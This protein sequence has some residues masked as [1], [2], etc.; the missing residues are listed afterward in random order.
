MVVTSKYLTLG[1][2]EFVNVARCMETGAISGGNAEVQEYEA[3]LSAAFSCAQAIACS[4]GT[5]AIYIA[6]T[7]LG[8]HGATR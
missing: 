7:A 8:V 3:A 5:A 1:T 4:S 2:A 6:L